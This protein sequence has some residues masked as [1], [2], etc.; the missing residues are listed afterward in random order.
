MWGAS[1][2]LSYIQLIHQYNGVRQEG[3]SYPQYILVTDDETCSTIGNSAKGTSGFDYGNNIYNGVM[4]DCDFPHTDD[5]ND[6][7]S[8]I[9]FQMNIDVLDRA[10]KRASM[11][12]E[13]CQKEIETII[14]NAESLIS[15]LTN[16][17]QTYSK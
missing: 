15:N 5:V 17:L 2:D 12:N 14:S 3:N 7:L 16:Q 13:E 9:T 10:R 1:W 8:E 4:M 11:S 6:Y